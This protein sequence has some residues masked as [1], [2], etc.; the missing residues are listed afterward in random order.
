[1]AT[2]AMPA[3]GDRTAPTFDPKQPREL[4]RYF[5]DIELLFTRSNITDD[6]QKKASV[7]RYVDIDTSELWE[8]ILGTGN[9]APEIVPAQKGN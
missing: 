9:V 5:S 1:M 8:T 2:P 3:R 6:Q 4:R 7:C